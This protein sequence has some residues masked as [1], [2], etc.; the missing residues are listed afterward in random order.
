MISVELVDDERSRR[1]ITSSIDLDKV[2]LLAASSG[3]HTDRPLPVPLGVLRKEILI[4]FRVLGQN[5]SQIPVAASERNSEA[6]Q[7]ALMHIVRNASEFQ[8]FRNGL[9]DSLEG[10]LTA[11]GEDVAEAVYPITSCARLGITSAVLK[12]RGTNMLEEAIKGIRGSELWDAEGVDRDTVWNVLFETGKQHQEGEVSFVDLL[13]CAIGS[14]T[15]VVEIES[16]ARRVVVVHDLQV[17]SGTGVKMIRDPWYDFRA[18]VSEGMARRRRTHHDRT[19]LVALLMALTFLHGVRFAGRACWACVRWVLEFVGIL[20]FPV[21]V[22]TSMISHA[23]REHLQV[24]G[25]KGSYVARLDCRRTMKQD[26]IEPSAL[27]KRVTRHRGILYNRSSEVIFDPAYKY[28]LM[29]SMRPRLTGFLTPAVAALAVAT[30]FSWLC[31]INA[32]T[33]ARDDA[34]TGGVD[35]NTVLLFSSSL[36]SLYVARP[37]EH[38]YRGMMLLFPRLAVVLSS[39][40][41]AAIALTGIFFGAGSTKWNDGPRTHGEAVSLVES[42]AK[43]SFTVCLGVCAYFLV[44]GMIASWARWRVLFHSEKNDNP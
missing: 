21:G 38:K 3:I 35:L 13:K 12:L 24:T 10:V 9:G 25:P 26:S 33:I 27:L 30:L 29:A 40:A 6:W 19:M 39:I 34:P 16:S 14:F 37:D 32:T 7:G 42:V 22:E 44:F 1:R 20:G 23:S 41:P 28:E 2:R 11:L 17:A 5:G 8:D 4:D 18:E 36:W 15:P 43:I 31:W